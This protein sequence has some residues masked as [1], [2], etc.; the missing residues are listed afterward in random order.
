MTVPIFWDDNEKM[1]HLPA[2]TNVVIQRYDNNERTL[3]DTDARIP[4]SEYALLGTI[5]ASKKDYQ[6]YT[7]A[8]H[9]YPTG[10][11]SV[12]S[13]K[14]LL[15]P[16]DALMAYTFENDANT[17]DTALENS[18]DHPATDGIETVREIWSYQYGC[19]S[20][21]NRSEVMEIDYCHRYEG[22]KTYPT[23]TVFDEKNEADVAKPDYLASYIDP[24]FGNRV[25]R[26]TDRANQAGNAKPYPKTQVWNADQS[27]IRLGYHLYWADSFAETAYTQNEHLR[28]SLTEMKCSSYEPNVFY[29]IDVRPDKYNGGHVSCRNYQ[30][31]GWC[32]LNTRYL[33]DGSGMR[34]VFA[35]KLDGSG[36]VERFAQTHNST[37]YGCGVQV[38]VSPDGTQLLFNSDWGDDESVKET[39]HI[40]VGE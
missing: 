2:N 28:G 16:L 13:M 36:T 38:N 29:G 11:R 15:K 7:P 12:D 33:W 22:G 6:V 40:K 24:V 34:E 18:S 35:L 3:N 37:D 5:D 20:H 39:Y 1:R 32:Y 9:S 26:I 17:H 10:N 14:A 19:N 21:I 30:R 23:D 4:L 27:I 31:P 8:T 25:T